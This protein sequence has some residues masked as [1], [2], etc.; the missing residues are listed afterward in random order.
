LARE[1]PILC[2]CQVFCALMT[3]GP[4]DGGDLNPVQTRPESRRRR[5][6]RWVI[7]NYPVLSPHMR[8]FARSLSSPGWPR[9]HSAFTD[10]LHEGPRSRRL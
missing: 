8:V 7:S 2:L 9:H 4:Q 3:Y 1:V 5:V 10:V 6:C